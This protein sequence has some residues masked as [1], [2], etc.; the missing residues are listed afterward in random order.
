MMLIGDRT[1]LVKALAEGEMEQLM[2]CLDEMLVNKIRY[3]S[4]S[5]CQEREIQIR[6]TTTPVTMRNSRK[7]NENDQV[8]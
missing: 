8:S 3:Y 7:I 2:K 1:L 5:P 4:H 6:M